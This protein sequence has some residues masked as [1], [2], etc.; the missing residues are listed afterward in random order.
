V[1]GELGMHGLN[2]S[3]SGASNVASMRVASMRVAQEDV[4]LLPEFK[5][6]SIFV[7]TAQFAVQIRFD[8]IH[9]YYGRADAY[10]HMGQA[11]GNGMIQLLQLQDTKEINMNQ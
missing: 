5:N 7:R 4:C 8:G 6:T 1:I 9:H 10:F 11:L 2:V 3:G